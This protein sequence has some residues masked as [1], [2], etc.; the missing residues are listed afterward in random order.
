MLAAAGRVQPRRARL[1]DCAH[2]RAGEAGARCERLRRPVPSARRRWTCSTPSPLLEPD[3]GSAARAPARPPARSHPTC[4][5]RRRCCSKAG[6]DAARRRDDEPRCAT[7]S[8]AP[9]KPLHRYRCAACGFEAEHYFWQ[10]PG[11]LGW[12]TLPAATA[13]R[14]V[15]N[16]TS[17]PRTTRRGRACWW[18]ATRCST[19]TGSARS[20]A[21]RPRRRCRWCASTREE[22]RL[23][24][25]ANV[26]STSRRSA[27]RPAC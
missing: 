25:A 22:E 9:R 16:A 20:S 8:T 11:C 10:C 14:S 15:M 27:R 17:D 23:G 26:A 12:D 19:A 3:A 21:S 18:S 4:R 1:R 6:H 7:R 13:G 24:G 2:R 5:P